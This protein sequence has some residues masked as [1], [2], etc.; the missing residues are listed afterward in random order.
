MDI[1]VTISKVRKE[2]KEYLRETHPDWADT[3]ISTHVSD[4]FYL[5]QNTIALSFWKCFESDA[6]ME[7][8]KGE[9]LDYLKQEVM[10]D[11]ADERTAQYYRDLKR[12]KEFIDSKGGVKTY[13]GYEYDC[14]VIVY[15]Y[16]KMVYDGTMEMDAAVKAMC[17][18]V[19]CFGETSHKLT[20]ML[21][22]SMMKG[23]KYTRRSNTETTV[24]FIVHIGKDYGQEQ[25][26]NALKATQ[27][28][29]KYYYEQTGNKSNS[30]RRGCKKIVEENNIDISFDDEIFDGIIPK[31]N[32]DTALSSDATATHYWLYAAGDGSANWENDYAEGIMAIGWSDLGDLMEYSS[33][34]EMRAKMKEVYGDTGSYKNQV[35]ATW[36]FANEL[37]P[38]DVVFVKKGRKQ[39]LGRGLVEGEYVFDPERGQYANTRKVRWTDKGEWELSDQGAIKTLTDITSYTDYV[40]KLQNMIDGDKHEDT[41]D[42]AADEEI[43]FEPY[44]ADDF[45]TDVYMDEDRY[46][47]LKSLLLTKKNVIL[48]GAPGVGKTFAAKRLAF[49]IMGEKDTNRVKM[50]QFH[51][52][53][54]FDGISILDIH[55]IN[56]DIQYDR[57]NQT[58]RML[59]AVCRFVI[60]GLLQTTAD[61]S[62]KIMDYADDQTMAKLYEKFILGYYQRE[63]P[64]LKAYSPQIAWQVTDG[65]RTLLP[66]MQSDIVITNKAAK[67]TLIIDAKYYTHNMQ[68]KAPYMTQTLHSG[69]LYQ[70][71]TYVKNWSAA[72]DEVVS[73]MLLYAGTDDAIQ[74][75][76][77][78]QMSGNQISVKTLDM[79]C[80]FS[81]IAAQLDSIADRIK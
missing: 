27:E 81:K 55:S 51:Q 78:Y 16:A 9:I 1:G 15:K 71:F 41:F 79:D 39:I 17:Q 35:L 80:D 37:K 19:P 67:K 61:G 47:V 42:D 68:M 65:Y 6:A 18:D 32:T 5:Y 4:A 11:R 57:N 20:I 31:E 46:K 74:P 56:W 58:Y 28:N 3:T 53:F 30:I 40:K 45:L 48:Q 26:V 77:D 8:A 2:Y 69:N 24:Y 76:N 21:F 54:S 10:S 14:E 7:K 63:H 59:I 29:I 34:E 23:V 44:T 38:G 50:V 73:G 36:Q 75:N 62:T 66:T 22:A 64:E 60:K 52:S 70:I 13:I 33:K 49:S 43:T 12:L 25:M 72:P